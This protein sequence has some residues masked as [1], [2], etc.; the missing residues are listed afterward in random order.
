MTVQLIG[1][2]LGYM[3]VVFQ[4][5]SVRQFDLQHLQAAIRAGLSTDW[6][7]L[8]MSAALIPTLGY[9]VAAA[10]LRLGSHGFLRLGFHLPSPLQS[11]LIVGLVLPLQLISVQFFHLAKM[12]VP[13]TGLDQFLTDLKPAPLFS[14]ILLIAVIPALWEELLC[15]GL[16]GRGLISRWGLIPGILMTSVLFG[17]MHLNPAHAVAVIPLGIALHYVYLT[18]R[19]LWGPMLLHF[20]NN[21]ISVVL[22]KHGDGAS[23]PGA[24]DTAATAEFPLSMLTVSISIVVTVALQMLL[25]QIRT[26]FVREDGDEWDPGYASLEVPPAELR[27]TLVRESPRRLLLACSAVC[28][29]GFLGVVMHLNKLGIFASK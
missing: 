25:W 4:E 21:A 26:R 22:L 29:M 3:V 11:I 27:G 10:W 8:I 23:G 12:I 6:L 18:T 1:S 24:T 9:T 28:L 16:I 19:T 5:L 15:R 17:A 20:L 7:V 13:D 2:L 14:L